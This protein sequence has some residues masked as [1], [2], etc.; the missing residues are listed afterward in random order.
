MIGLVPGRRK[1]GAETVS[2]WKEG[3]LTAWLGEKTPVAM[4]AGITFIG[5]M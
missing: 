4:K 3:R 5:L 1:A 2:E